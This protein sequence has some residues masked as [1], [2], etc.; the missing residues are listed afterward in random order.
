MSYDDGSLG[1]RGNGSPADGTPR[2]G[3][4][5]KLAALPG[6]ITRGVRTHIATWPRRYVE[7][8]SARYESRDAK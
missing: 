1:Q 6:K 3:P 2:R 7:M 8:R 4:L 5:W